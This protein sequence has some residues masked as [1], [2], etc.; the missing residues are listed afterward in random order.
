MAVA[1]NKGGAVEDFA[2]IA[3]L[4]Y[5]AVKVVAVRLD[6]VAMEEVVDDSQVDPYLAL[7]DA[8]FFKDYQR[9]GG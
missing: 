3:D 1:D 2:V 6:F 8:E 9:G 7:A 5:E 4:P